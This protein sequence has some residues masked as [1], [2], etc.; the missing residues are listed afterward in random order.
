VVTVHCLQT[1]L[2]ADNP[3][4]VG[5]LSSKATGEPSYA[6]AISAHFA[7]KY[8]VQSA[9]SDAGVTGTPPTLGV[10]FRL[11]GLHVA[12]FLSCVRSG[13]FDLAMPAT[14][15]VVATACGTTTSMLQLNIPSSVE[16]A[17]SFDAASGRTSSLPWYS[18]A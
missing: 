5:V 1:T 2:L 9:R 16:A 14:P 18:R 7:V 4:P 12:R 3:N 13:Y 15:C 10:K 6:L 17:S 11:L 8:A